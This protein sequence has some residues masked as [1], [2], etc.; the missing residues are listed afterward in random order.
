MAASTLYTL[1]V[2]LGLDVSTL[3]TDSQKAKGVLN[4]IGSAAARAGQLGLPAAA[5]LNSLAKATQAVAGSTGAA[6]T[7]TRLSNAVGAVSAATNGAIGPLNAFA[8]GAEAVASKTGSGTALNAYA[9][10]MQAIAESAGGGEAAIMS[11]AAASGQAAGM[12]ATNFTQF[13]NSVRNAV[14][15]AQHLDETLDSLGKGSSGDLPIIN[16][17]NAFLAQIK[18]GEGRLA[19]FAQGVEALRTKLAGLSGAGEFDAMHLEMMNGMLQAVSNSA[20]QAGPSIDRLEQLLIE[21]A[22]AIDAAAQ[23]AKNGEVSI[24]D[25]GAA[26]EAVASMFRRSEWLS[27]FTGAELKAA[28]AAEDLGD[29]LER[30]AGPERQASEQTMS[31]TKRWFEMTAAFKDGEINLDQ[32]EASLASLN[33]EVA[34]L[35]GVG[36]MFEGMDADMNRSIASAEQLLALLDRMHA[37]GKITGPQYD[38]LAGMAGEGEDISQ[39]MKL[40]G[41]LDTR[42]E[43][44][45]MTGFEALGAVESMFRDAEKAASEFAGMISEDSVQARAL[46][47]ILSALEMFDELP[48][49]AGALKTELENIARSGAA[50]EGQIKSLRA[51]VQQLLA[52]SEFGPASIMLPE[53]EIK[54][55]G[56]VVPE[57]LEKAKAQAQQLLDIL[58]G[59]GQ[60]AKDL[61]VNPELVPPGLVAYLEQV[62]STGQIAADELNNIGAQV[63][64]LSAQSSVLDRITME[65]AASEQKLATG[66]NEVSAAASGAEKKLYGAAAASHA[67]KVAADAAAE[68]ARREAAALSMGGGAGSSSGGGMGGGGGGAGGGGGFAAGGPGGMDENFNRTT[69]AAMRT[70]SA[71]KQVGTA[72]EEV[73]RKAGFLQRTLSMAF[74]FGGGV[75]VTTAIGFIGNALLGFNSRLQ[76][77]HIAFTTLLGDAGAADMFIKKMQDFANVTPFDFAGVQDATQRLLAMGFTADQVLPTLRA[78]GDAVA[79]LGGS[80]DTLDRV[81]LAL[82]QMK[83]AAHLNAQ[84]M[85]QLTEA[86]IPAWQMLADSIHKSVG[87]TVKMAAAGQITTA[88][89]VP[90]IIEGMNAKFAG[91]MAKQARTA[92]GAFST[93]RDAALQTISGAI[94]PLF[95]LLT[96]VLAGIADFFVAGGGKYIVPLI[97][98]IGVAIGAFLIPRLVALIGKIEMVKVSFFGM[99]LPLLPLI[100]AVYLFGLAWQE[101]FGGIRTVLDP[102]VSAL[103]NL[104]RAVLEA[105]ANSGLLIPVLTVIA[106]IL[107]VKMLVGL[108]ATAAGMVANALASFA[109]A[110]AVTTLAFA[111]TSATVATTGFGAS[112][113]R[114]VAMSA[115]VV[116]LG[117]VIIALF[118]AIVAAGVLLILNWDRVGQG[119][120]VLEFV[121]LGAVEGILRAVTWLPF[122]GDGFKNMAD[123]VHEAQMGVARDMAAMEQHIHDLEEAQNKAGQPT[124]VADLS[125]PNKFKAFIDSFKNG[126]AQVDDVTTKLVD[127]FG[128]TM[129]GVVAAAKAAGADAMKEMAKAITDHQNAPLDAMQQLHD[130][131]RTAMTPEAEIARNV[132]ILQSNEMAIGLASGIPAVRA[133]AEAASKA[134]VER[135]D[136]LTNGA[137]SAGH[138][139]TVQLAAGMMD[140]DA[141]QSVSKAL[142]MVG[143]PIA[144]LFDSLTGGTAG[145]SALNN[146]VGTLGSVSQKMAS[147]GD[148]N[149]KYVPTASAV[150]AAQKAMNDQL[151]ATARSQGL[152]ALSSAFSDIQQSAHKMFEQMH[153]DNLQL[154][155][156]ALKHKNAL[157]DAKEALNQAPVTAAQKALDFQRK[158]IQEW[159]LRQAVSHA[160]TP[161][162]YRDAVLALQDFLAQ[163]HIDEMQ[164]Q[165]DTAKDVIEQ[166]KQRNTDLA[167]LQKEAENRRYDMQQQAFDHELKLLQD[168]LAKHPEEWANTQGKIMKLLNSYGISYQTAGSSLGHYFVL[169]LQSQIDAA[170]AAVKQL[171]DLIPGMEDYLK[172]LGGALGAGQYPGSGA[173]YG[174]TGTAPGSTVTAAGSNAGTGIGAGIGA[175]GSAVTPIL[176][177]GGSASGSAQRPK[178]LD[179]GAWKIM[180]D[181][182]LASLHRD[183]MVM[184]ADVASLAR[185]FASKSIS[186][187]DAFQRLDMSGSGASG[188]GGTIIFQVGEEVLGEASDRGLKVQGD[189]Y[190]NH[191]RVKVRSGR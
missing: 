103:A 33:A 106:T 157:L 131:L 173:G 166:Q 178:P 146:L 55:A 104:S 99:E 142:E 88:Q 27:E 13:S 183:E 45:G 10:A 1:L 154:I 93:I 149:K 94:A 82:G 23:T 57:G 74:A 41:D 62:A 135:L 71:V 188:P 86:G 61:H 187:S 39:L 138:D 186:P 101:N 177:G 125:D 172:G 118:A 175:V 130:L 123:G 44:L 107:G 46:L 15:E 190:G 147:A 31:L 184:P 28:L 76:Q 14:E 98:A 12:G 42:I 16:E 137:Y 25:L 68:A 7:L 17:I 179:V 151:S 40:V 102:V 80:R 87:E 126:A 127:T 95:D 109:M 112:L 72:V 48:Q 161:E 53:Y 115:P 153:T 66:L 168:Y 116:A 167:A 69:G 162:E 47:D 148:W 120:R 143:G 29:R 67:K 18:G 159:R 6:I 3:Q 56:G 136:E 150:T 121:F 158:A 50:A 32:F 119:V 181:N 165:V 52:A 139:T 122:V 5:A 20:S 134:A 176:N 100:A 117:G 191:R 141:L 37:E 163:K 111:E 38:K 81:T 113:A 144:K 84:D 189:I 21:A 108:A 77:A 97:Y 65:A 64:V 129:E 174:G 114:L 124:D 60:V 26:N 110:G 83:T 140:P 22:G 152:S 91:L 164:A 160:S 51:S 96:N 78:V 36:A 58:N 180:K 24:R 35:E 34:S 170:I 11:F 79:G 145:T 132:G 90:A 19:E 182:M 133:A 9:R 30:L 105:A 73:S 92:Q 70:T 54:Q 63:D 85:R 128:T 2:K 169:G 171:A 156:D 8:A 89:A 59:V 185:S 75:A 43:Q 49:S 155:D 4:D